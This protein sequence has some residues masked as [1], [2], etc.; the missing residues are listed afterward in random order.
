MDLS[1]LA[2]YLESKAKA[3]RTVFYSQLVEEF[4][5]PPIDGAWTGHP[6]ERA[7]DALDQEDAK[8]GRPFRTSVVVAKES[9]MPGDGYFKSLAAL[10]NIHARSDKQRL[11]VF[12]REFA[13]AIDYEW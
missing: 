11:E 3:K 9:G 10:R 6:L 5:L 12:T 8:V 1:K 13:A 2:T 7:F 4:G